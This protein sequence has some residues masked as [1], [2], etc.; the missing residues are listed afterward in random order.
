MFC[1]LLWELQ[2]Q[3]TPGVAAAF[4]VPWR[5][6][7]P[8]IQMSIFLILVQ[9][10][11]FPRPAVVCG[12]QVFRSHDL[13]GHRPW[14]EASPRGWCGPAW[15]FL[16]RP[17]PSP[18]CAGERLSVATACEHQTTDWKWMNMATTERIL[19]IVVKRKPNAI[20]FWYPILNP[21]HFVIWDHVWLCN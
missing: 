10:N 4:G 8:S 1:S 6:D 13:N 7:V 14:P 5:I 11:Y 20:Y 2:S 16:R 3:P 12:G 19:Y 9:Q 15:F 21:I 18:I 17:L